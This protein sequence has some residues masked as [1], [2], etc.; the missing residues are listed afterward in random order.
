MAV[1]LSFPLGLSILHLEFLLLFVQDGAFLSLVLASKG[2][3]D[4][5]LKTC[6]WKKL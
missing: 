6:S 1:E 3:V 5:Q 2:Y 4:I